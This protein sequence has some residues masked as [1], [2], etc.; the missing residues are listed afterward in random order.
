VVG[1]EA[2]LAG[3]GLERYASAFAS[4]DVDFETLALLGDA[5]LEKLGLSLGHRRKL[6]RAL[7]EFS[8][9]GA[10]VESARGESRSEATVEH[11]SPRPAEAGQRRHLTV[12]FCDLV[13]STQLSS[14]LD[15][16]DLQRIVREYHAAVATA[17]A[18][19]DG[20]VAQLLGD[21]VLVYFGYPRAHEDDAGRAVHAALN[22]LKVVADLGAYGGVELQTRIGIATGLVVV[23]EIGAGTPAAELTASGAT[24][25]LAARLQAR[26]QPGEIVLS[27][28][29]R[30][31]A[32][33]AF[34]L[35]STGPLELKGFAVPITAWR[36]KGERNVASR[37]DAQHE[38]ELSAFIGRDSEIALLLDRWVLARGG[39]GQ[40]VLLS[41]EAGIGKSRIS[42]TLRER[43]SGE[44]H[45]TVVLQ[46]SPYFSSSALYPLVQYFERVARFTATDSTED[47]VSKL[48]RLRGPDISMPEPSF[49]Y[50]LRM[51]GLPD[52]GRIPAGERAPQQ[53]K[54]LTLQAPI[55]LLRGLTEHIPVLM[56]IEDAHWIDPTTDQVI[57]LA[58]EQLRESRLLTL[59]T[60]RPEYTAPW[61][62][63]PH[64]TRLT[65]NRLGQ[66]Q[67]IA[68]VGAVSGGRPLPDAVLTEI[69]RKTD[70]IPLFVEELTKTVLQSGLLELTP[71]GYQLT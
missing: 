22:V 28:E 25:N 70:G 51:M 33:G 60:C 32:G 23:G 36:V 65:L 54:A 49:G 64:L 24:P 63:L 13:G 30:R 71:A 37:F 57:G 3:L 61:G 31:L 11:A 66:K 15:P 59:I 27:D 48:E 17:V 42:Q 21:G 47:R 4:N 68:L 40:A 45:A 19:F 55:D 35:E 29:T 43:L 2:W 9:G 5:D 14:R 8:D 1:L 44:P 53:E 62:N 34:D 26:A 56:L 46:C 50:L 39:E 12:M 41:G 16:E 7:A 18:P 6:L 10:A 58:I 67:C 69:V 20:Y 38:D 52:G